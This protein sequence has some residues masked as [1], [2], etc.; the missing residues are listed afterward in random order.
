MCR[1][2]PKELE[3]I[4]EK[5][6]ASFLKEGLSEEEA[7]A[8]TWESFSLLDPRELELFD[9]DYPGPWVKI[10]GICWELIEGVSNC[11]LTL[12]IDPSL[13]NRTSCDKKR[14]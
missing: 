9:S 7:D 5:E 6:Y 14:K 4:R 12:S 1:R 2:T 11:D 3:E 13:V 8:V 10:C